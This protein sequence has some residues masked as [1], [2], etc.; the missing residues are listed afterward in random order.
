[1]LIGKVATPATVPTDRTT[2]KP[3]SSGPTSKNSPSGVASV[4]SGTESGI[5]IL[6]A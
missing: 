5:A 2:L 1:M 4:C 6:S 3:C